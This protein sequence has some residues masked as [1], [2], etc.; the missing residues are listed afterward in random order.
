MSGGEP[1]GGEP[2]GVLIRAATPEDGETVWPFWHRVVATGETY[3]YDPDLTREQATDMWLLAPPGR[4]VVAVTGDG[5]IA[6]TAKM[7]PNQGGR[8]SHVATAS[9]LVDPAHARR[10]VGRALGE[11]AVGWARDECYR[12]MQFNAVVE[13]NTPAVALWTALGFEVL[14]TV[15]EAFLHPTHGYVG[16]HVMYRRL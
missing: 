1:S 13:T 6:G 5:E 2:S 14:T 3:T 15:P 11:Y 4:T 12:A 7:G 8:G 9:F 10:G 16:L